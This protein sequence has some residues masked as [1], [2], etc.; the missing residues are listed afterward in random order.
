MP[1]TTNT[2]DLTDIEITSGQDYATGVAEAVPV[3]GGAVTSFDAVG[4]A[5][6]DGTLA[7]SEIGSLESEGQ[8]FIQSCQGAAG[9]ATDPIGWLVGN[10]LDFL[11]AVVQPLQDA[12]HF[13]TGDGPALSQAAGNFDNIGHGLEKIKADFERDLHQSLQ[14]WSGE[15]SDAAGSKLAEFAQGIDGVAGQAGDIAH[16][17]H[18]SSM[19]MNVIESFLKAILTELITWL[20]TIWI[21]ALAAAVPTCGAS[22]AAAGSAT[23]VRAGTTT[24]RVTRQVSTLRKI[25]DLLMDLLRK[26][27]RLAGKARTKISKGMREAQAARLDRGFGGSMKKTA[28]EAA[29]DE[30]SNVSNHNSVGSAAKSDNIGSEQS[31]RQT[32]TDLDL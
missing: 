16:L 8:A 20:I 3:V 26:L 18:I 25:L 31:R 24:M 29:S 7:P 13:V 2:G 22:T 11:L 4:T 30:V 23:A 9:I 32:A 6:E 5:M 28:R 17:L 15:A 1:E 21:P 12:V 27:A 10:G 14:S 19:I